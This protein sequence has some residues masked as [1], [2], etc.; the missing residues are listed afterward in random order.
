[1]VEKSSNSDQP[2]MEIVDW[3]L[4][5]GHNVSAE[6]MICKT[7]KTINLNKEMKSGTPYNEAVK[8]AC[9]VFKVAGWIAND[10]PEADIVFCPSCT[11][12]LRRVFNE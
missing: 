11:E 4:L 12:R 6:C 9:E 5:M 10:A 3:E 2:T 7:H 1:M 8:K